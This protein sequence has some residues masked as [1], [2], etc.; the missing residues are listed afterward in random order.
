MISVALG[1]FAILAALIFFVITPKYDAT[2]RI[3][4][5]P[6]RNPLAVEQ[7]G[8]GPELGDPAM[9]TE[10][11]ILRSQDVARETVR[12]LRLQADPEFL[13]LVSSR[14]QLRQT[15]DPALINAVAERIVHRLTV[16]RE[17]TSY[18]LEA[19]FRSRDPVK[20]AKIVNMIAQ[21][22]LDAR[23]GSL[24]RTSGRQSAWFKQRLV[25]LEAEVRAADARL[26]SYRSRSG[27]GMGAD[28]SVSNE[29]LAPLSTELATAEAAAAAARSNLTAARNEAMSGGLDAV[30]AA[31]ASQ[32]TADLR[33]QRAEIV[34]RMN[35]I[36]GRSGE[37]HPETVMVRKQLAAIDAQIRDEA[38]RALSTLT[39]QASSADAQAS[40]LRS[41]MRNLEGR[42]AN[43]TRNSP[44]AESLLREA[45]SK[46]AAYDRLAQLSLE[47][48]QLARDSIAHAEVVDIAEPP[49][50]A[51]WPQKGLLL[52]LAG[53]AG[54]G[55]GFLST[56]MLRSIKPNFRSV[57]D[58]EGMSGVAL[59]TSV[60]NLEESEYGSDRS[61]ADSLIRYPASM[62][63]ESLRNLQ[64]SVEAA[65]PAEPCRVVALTSAVPEEGKT[66]TALSFARV[67]AIGGAKTL[68]IDCDVRRASLR[69]LVSA[70]RKPGLTDVLT[71]KANPVHAITT[72]DIEGLDMILM[73]APDFSGTN[74]FGNGK[75]EALV[76]QFRK[77]YQ[78]IVLD[79]PPMLGVADARFLSQ[80]ADATVLVVRWASTLAPAVSEALTWLRADGANLIG[81]VYTRVDPKAKA[82][83]AYHHSKKYSNYYHTA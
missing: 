82:I 28:G 27:L 34:E 73:R 25:E 62:F 57:G 65:C 51:A 17:S 30:S 35:E 66:T 52:L 13:E 2:T 81:V 58:I 9:D 3:Q 60:P 15:S 47:S 39:A 29:Q 5:D 56:E 40:S 61:P 43:Y 64:V 76:E 77:T 26:S 24:M 71:G 69:Y 31:G 23:V 44:V 6:S 45:E 8:R 1:V 48:T 22:Y 75:M 20:S 42:Q 19:T 12:R 41:A 7:N 32:V 21:V 53:M 18:I 16:Q 55:A 59:L 78:F 10:I 74:Y 63:A 83:G 46:R 80:Q 11:S 14:D 36:V 54:A 72:D 4:I 37:N 33:R 38:Q 68:L 67:L 70:D 79:L 49:A 50:E